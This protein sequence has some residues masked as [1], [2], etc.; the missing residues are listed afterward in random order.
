MNI[1]L[2]NGYLDIKAVRAYMSK[3]N[4]VYAFIWGSRG[5]GKTFG[6]F[7]DVLDKHEK[8]MMLRRTK[9]QTDLITNDKFSPFK[10]I[11]TERGSNIRPFPLG[12]GMYGFYHSEWDPVKSKWLKTGDEIGIAAAVSTA[13]NIR[14]YDGSDIDVII[15]DEFIP[16]KAERPIKG[17][18]G[19]LF[20]TI[21]TVVRNRELQ[22][23]IC[24]FIALSNSND[25]D[26]PY[27]LELD[28]VNRALKMSQSKHDQVYENQKKRLLL[29]CIN[30]SPIARK[31]KDTSLYQ[32]TAGSDYERMALDNDFV[33]VD[34]GSVKSLDLR[35]W[36]PEV[37]LG[38]ICLYKSTQYRGKW[39]VSQYTPKQVPRTYTTSE[40]SL[41]RFRFKYGTLYNAYI[42]DDIT[43]EDHQCEYL[44]TVYLKT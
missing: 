12:S 25:V 36:K 39:Y 13:G 5:I 35:H 26:N 3:K 27:F 8:F 38:G 10:A 14:G 37:A 28:L 44:F 29:L 9:V 15:Y 18:A 6:L 43:F 20:D 24:Q 16:K 30:E 1:Y 32:L 42:N 4:L 40:I 34:T 11:N 21:E 7:S 2:D 19:L 17:E 33:E 23:K 41:E 22:G 31:K